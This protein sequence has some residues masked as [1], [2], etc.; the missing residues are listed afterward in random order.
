MHVNMDWRM[1]MLIWWPA[2]TNRLSSICY[3]LFWWRVLKKGRRLCSELTSPFSIVINVQS[4]RRTR[5]RNA[6]IFSHFFFPKIVVCMYCCW[7]AVQSYNTSRCVYWQPLLC[8]LIGHR[9]IYQQWIMCHLFWQWLHCLDSLQWRVVFCGS[10]MVQWNVYWL[11]APPFSC[12]INRWHCRHK[13]NQ[14][15]SV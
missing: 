3:F 14:S 13:H 6:S 15:Q 11:V 4:M 12:F 7:Y 8:F 10:M 5:L 1:C 9:S 2:Y